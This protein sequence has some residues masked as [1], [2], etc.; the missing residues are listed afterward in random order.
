MCVTE[1]KMP[2]ISQKRKKYNNE[3]MQRAREAKFKKTVNLCDLDTEIERKTN[4][5]ISGGLTTPPCDAGPQPHVLGR[6]VGREGD[7]SVS[8]GGVVDPR[9]DVTNVNRG[10]S[11]KNGRS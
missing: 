10:K 9:G 11:F 3:K 8:G 4:V 1:Y 7:V 6:G 5:S 2:G